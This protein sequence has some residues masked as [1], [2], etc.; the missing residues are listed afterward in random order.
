[1]KYVTSISW[2]KTNAREKIDKCAP[3]EG[4]SVKN[5]RKEIFHFGKG[6]KVRI[7]AV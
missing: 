3:R 2:T 7:T 4:N 5:E 1:M 6:I